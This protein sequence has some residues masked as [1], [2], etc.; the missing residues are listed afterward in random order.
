VIKVPHHGGR[1]SASKPFLDAV[2]PDIA[3]IS[4][5]RDNQ[6]GHPHQ[7]TLDTLSGKKVLRTDTGGAIKIEKTMQGYD[8]ETYTDF[9]FE[10]A[11][12][13]NREMRNMKRLFEQW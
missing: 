12:A 10:K 13:L 6:F 8:V 2:N 1:T 9:Q 7:E 5:E 3:V 4:T 11:Y